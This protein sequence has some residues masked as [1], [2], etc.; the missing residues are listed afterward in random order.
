MTDKAKGLDARRCK[1]KIQSEDEDW[2]E[3]DGGTRGNSSPS[4]NNKCSRA[5]RKKGWGWGIMNGSE[6]YGYENNKRS[7][8]LCLEELFD[9]LV[10]RNLGYIGTSVVKP[11]QHVDL[12]L[13]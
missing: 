4:N 1:I 5:A 11:P 13:M 8:S 2:Q 10:L 9:D 7:E 3:D 6:K 12:A